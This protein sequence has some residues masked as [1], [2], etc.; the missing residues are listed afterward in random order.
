[1]MEHP[2]A[3]TVK[4]NAKTLIGT[5]VTVGQ[6][7]PEFTLRKQD[8]SELKLSELKGKVTVLVTVPSLDTPVC[9][10]EVRRFNQEA[11]SLGPI[12]IVVVSVDLPMAQ[13]RWCG[14]AGVDKVMTA[15]DYYDLSFGPRYGLRIKELGLLAR[16]VIVLDKQ[17]VVRHYELVKEVASEPNY[18]AALEAAKKLV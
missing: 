8:L 1:M 10:T 15:S 2:G 4:G 6:A 17:G 7:A 5:Q 16:S 12:A 14:A 13:K 9:D 3:V 18:Q 11:A